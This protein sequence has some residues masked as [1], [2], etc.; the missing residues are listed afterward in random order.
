MNNPSTH[1]QTQSRNPQGIC[2]HCGTHFT[3]RDPQDEFCCSGCAYVHRLIHEKALDQ[4]Y[5]LKDEVTPPVGTAIFNSD[6][7]AWLESRVCEAESLAQ[8]N[9][10]NT[11]R[12]SLRVQGISCVACVW[13][14]EKV[15]ESLPGT[16]DISL[17]VRHGQLVLDWVSG[18]FAAVEFAQELKALGYILCPDER[19]ENRRESRSVGLKL[20]LCAAFAMNTML[21]TLPRYLGMEA[22][23]F[24]ADT[25]SL[26]A[27]LFSTLSM[28]VGGLY[29]IR[30]A[31]T[32][33]KM[34]T[35]HMD[36]PI[37]LGLCA[38]YVGSLGGWLIGREDLIYFDFVAVFVLLMLLGRWLQ[39]TVLEH[40]RSRYLERHDVPQQVTRILEGSEVTQPIES[41]EPGQVLC[42]P[43]NGMI[44]VASRLREGNAS[45][46]L[47]CINGEQD[48][49]EF[50]AG[51]LLPSGAV[52]CGNHALLIETLEPWQD[53]LLARLTHRESIHL[54]NALLDRILRQYLAVIMCVAG[55]GGAYWAIHADAVQAFQVVIS[56]LV[57]SC[58]CAIGVALPLLNEIM[59]V[60]VRRR[61]VYIRS[62][63]LWSALKSVRTLVF[64]KTGTLTFEKPALNNPEVLRAL[65]PDDRKLLIQLTRSSLHPLCRSLNQRLSVDFADEAAAGMCGIGEGLK[66]LEEIPGSGLC[67]QVKGE[68][69]SLGKP[70]WK[71]DANE[72]NYADLVFSRAGKILAEF[73]FSEQLRDASRQWLAALESQ[74]Y[75][76]QILS[77][78]REEKVFALADS[79]GLAQDRV[80]ARQSPEDKAAWIQAHGGGATLMVGD[81]LNDSL[82]LSQAT[83]SG[84]VVTDL[85]VL[86]HKADFLLMGSAIRGVVGL[87]EVA[88][89]RERTV[90]QLFAFNILYNVTVVTV[91]LAGA[92]NPLIA[93]IVMPLSSVASTLLTLFQARRVL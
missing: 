77:G 69:W 7:W 35:L 92:M 75:A 39:E 58:P 56:V 29:F 53:S 87:L 46:S 13:L 59:I 68:E 22:D 44:P 10:H 74:G 70:G 4:Y 62:E 27:L 28:L 31:W 21:A 64:D 30:R 25:L 51:E 43:A 71:A 32:G 54:K 89:L 34:R 37:A 48:L 40:N 73:T 90:R 38:A 20:G 9:G 66:N 52:H 78:D 82:A 33:L 57:V 5:S 72:R 45:L 84:V 67:F 11:A 16:V 18:E 41:V 88:R 3:Q 47:Q 24:L 23:F 12:L 81:G 65:T 50:T 86:G 17:D 42:I 49:R 83:C 6:D 2:K 26:V 85:N 63:A 80:C 61:G 60:A 8:A 91:A 55:L 79:L 19:N 93:A 15:F 76:L 1:R 14:V 36:F